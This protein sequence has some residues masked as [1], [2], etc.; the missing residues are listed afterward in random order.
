[1]NANQSLFHHPGDAF[2]CTL[3]AL[4]RH[5]RSHSNRKMNLRINHL[6][7]KC[8][9]FETYRIPT[10]HVSRLR[11]IPLWILTGFLCLINF[12]CFGGFSPAK[13]KRWFVS[14]MQNR[15]R[16]GD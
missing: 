1:M 5:K 10:P 4:G 8:V 7:S 3:S 16:R 13:F 2:S 9:Y 6:R 11:V 14:L 15:Y 12:L